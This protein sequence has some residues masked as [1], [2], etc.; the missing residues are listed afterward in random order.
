MATA[1][2]LKALM[3]PQQPIEIRTIGDLNERQHLFAPLRGLSA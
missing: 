2:N 3:P 1:M